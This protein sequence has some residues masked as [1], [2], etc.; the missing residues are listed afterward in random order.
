MSNNNWVLC[1]SRSRSRRVPRTCVD[2][3]G[4]ALSVKA[5]PRCRPIPSPQIVITYGQ[6]VVG[7]EK[8]LSLFFCFFHCALL[9]TVES[10]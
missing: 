5:S 9:N 2:S 6:G 8:A 10:A 7:L 3:P 1:K 4:V